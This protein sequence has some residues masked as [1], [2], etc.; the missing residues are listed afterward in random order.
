MCGIYGYIGSSSVKEV[1]EGIKRLEYRGYDS[2]GIAFLGQT[3]FENENIFDFKGLSVIKSQG[4]IEN[5]EKIVKNVSPYSELCIGHTRWATHGKPNVANSHPH[6][7]EKGK[8]ALVHNGIIENYT[9]LKEELGEVD[10]KSETDSEVVVQLFERLYDGYPLKTLKTLCDRLVGS[11]A[12]AFISP[13]YPDK[14]FVAKKNSPVVVGCGDDYGVVCSDLNSVGEV[15]KAYVLENN[16]FAVIERGKVQVYD[17]NLNEITLKDLSNVI[18][19]KRSGLGEYEHYMLKEIDE[20]PEAI[21]RTVAD[22]NNYEKLRKALP[23][24]IAKKI[25]RVLIIGCGTAFH[26]GLIG[27]RLFEE[28]GIKCQAEIASEF[29]YDK[30]IPEKNT[31][32]IFIS[33]SGET[34][35]TIKALKKCK[36][37]SLP[38]LAIT[39]VRNS[40]IT[41]E[42]DRVIYT[43]AGAEIG[44]ASTKAY[45]CQLAIFYL[46]S[47]YFNAI[48][49][50]DE[51]LV[52]DEAGRLSHLADKI[53]KNEI[54]PLCKLV[55]E[56]ISSAQSIYM[57]GRGLDY[58]IAREA[59]LKLKE[60]SYIHCEAYPAGELKHGTI[61]LIDSEKFVFAFATQSEIFEKTLNGVHEVVSRDGKVILFSQHMN[62]AEGLFRFVKL[63]AID[64]KYVPIFVINYMQ[65]IS[66][67]TSLKLGN[68][69]DKPRS[70]AKSVTVE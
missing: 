33:Q 65:L 52:F 40:S 62:E 49:N 25:K 53:E 17:E 18:R 10:F 5:L 43:N 27:K 12:F 23:L 45:N 21:R 16:Q 58:D 63:P 3:K 48:K 7:G 35:D 31:L 67:Y 6:V 4:Q 50:G 8:W 2:A 13:D 1:M 55:A 69:P 56:E 20:I 30:F 61:S 24:K 38:T 19:E 64:E 59:S 28:I 54:K 51:S 44:V 9:L 46:L 57:I 11:Y 32:A 34:A 41:F 39:N 15:K 66:Y 22:Y 37:Y 47:A 68:N 29:R 70:L 14:I 26:A 36:D 60:I 42:A